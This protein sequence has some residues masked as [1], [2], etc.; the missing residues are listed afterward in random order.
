M[1]SPPQIF[2]RQLYKRNIERSLKNY[3]KHNFLVAD[4]SENIE[5]RISDFNTKFDKVLIYGF[6]ESNLS[7]TKHADKAHIATNQANTIV[8]DEEY[9]PLVGKEYDLI[10]SNLSLHFVNDIPGALHQY[11]RCLKKDGLLIA[12]FFGP[13]TLGDLRSIFLELDNEQ[14][15]GITIHISP[16]IDMKDGAWLLQRAGFKDP[17]ADNRIISVK[18]KDIMQLFRDIKGFGQG[19]CIHIAHHKFLGK[20]YFQKLKHFY[21]VKHDNLFEFEIITITGFA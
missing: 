15:G 1:H 7:E 4:V 6:F 14:L 19:N 21:S 16:F 13:K 3:H 8:F 17:V 12:S 2:N 20:N 5:N 10:I 18:Y 11:K 9:N